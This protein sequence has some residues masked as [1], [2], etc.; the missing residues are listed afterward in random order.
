MAL[1]VNGVNVGR[2]ARPG[3]ENADELA[4]AQVAGDVPFR[5][6]DDAVSGQRPI[7]G[8]FSMVDGKRLRTLTMTCCLPSVSCQ[9]LKA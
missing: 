2:T 4:V 7:D 1:R 3:V 5:T 8:D 9:L 6:K